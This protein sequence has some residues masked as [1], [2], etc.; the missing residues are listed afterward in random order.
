[1]TVSLY[2]D[3][4]DCDDDDEIFIPLTIYLIYRMG[5]HPLYLHVKEDT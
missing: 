3:C 2:D 4:D 1:M 5:L